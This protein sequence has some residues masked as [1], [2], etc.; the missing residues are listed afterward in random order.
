MLRTTVTPSPPPHRRGSSVWE[1][2]LALLIGLIVGAGLSLVLVEAW[3]LLG[4]LTSGEPPPAT[5]AAALSPVAPPGPVSPLAGIFDPISIAASDS[6]VRFSLPDGALVYL[7]ASSEVEL[8][9]LAD[10]DTLLT[11]RRGKVLVF[12]TLRPGRTFFIQTPTGVR[13]QVIGSV[14]G[15]TFDPQTQAS[16]VD[17]LEGHC[18]LNDDED[19]SEGRLEISAGQS[20]R[21]EPGGTPVATQGSNNDEWQAIA[22]VALPTPTAGTGAV[23]APPPPGEEPA[24]PPAE[25]ATEAPPQPAEEATEAA[26]PEATPPPPAVVTATLAGPATATPASTPTRAATPTLPSARTA[27]PRAPATPTPNLAATRVS[28]CATFQAQ[29]PATPCP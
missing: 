4:P 14:M 13:A 11:L 25:A 18:A 5:P 9:R 6:V 19:D 12:I 15:M 8:T 10:T 2:F 29:F 26:P 3:V 16:A 17:C 7:A 21:V 24:Q 1:L 27:T 23:T 22:G 28:F 20:A